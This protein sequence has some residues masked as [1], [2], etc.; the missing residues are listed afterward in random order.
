MRPLPPT[1]SP[2]GEGEA[3]KKCCAVDVEEQEVWICTTAPSLSFWERDKR[4]R[5]FVKSIWKNKKFGFVQLHRPS[6]LEG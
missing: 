6:P 5:F 3:F 4:M 1:P 2:D